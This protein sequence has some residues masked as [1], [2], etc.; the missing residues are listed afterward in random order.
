[1][2]ARDISG[3]YGSKAVLVLG[4]WSL[5]LVKHQNRVRQSRVLGAAYGCG[6]WCKGAWEN[7]ESHR[8]G[9]AYRCGPW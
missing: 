4:I 5:C 7:W 3:Q 6:T 2:E 1:M 8:M 9:L